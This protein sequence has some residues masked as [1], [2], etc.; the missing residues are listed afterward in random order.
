[1]DVQADFRELLASF[2]KHGVEYLIVGGYAWAFDGAP[3]FTGDLDLF[4]RPDGGNA[5]RL[6]DALR[7]FGFGSLGLTASDFSSPGKVVQ[8]GV[9]T[10]CADLLTS[11]TGVSRARSAASRAG[12]SYGD[13]PVFFIGRGEFLANKRATGRKRDLADIEALGEE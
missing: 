10:A 9:S 12:G 8:L 5:A 6:L 3:R 11:L 4:V 13:V 7:E 2:N 1:M